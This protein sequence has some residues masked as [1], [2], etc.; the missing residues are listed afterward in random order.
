MDALRLDR[1]WGA[2]SALM[3]QLV[4]RERPSPGRC[5]YCHLDLPVSLPIAPIDSKLHVLTQCPGC[6]AVHHGEC[7]WDLGMC[8]NCKR[9]LD[10]DPAPKLHPPPEI[11]MVSA[12][13]QAVTLRFKH[14]YGTITRCTRCEGTSEFAVEHG[15]C[16]RCA[17]ADVRLQKRFTWIFQNRRVL[18]LLSALVL[19]ACTPL[20]PWAGCVA[21]GLLVASLLG[22]AALSPRTDKG[23]DKGEVK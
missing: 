13:P 11:T 17:T 9:P 4:V 6:R 15:L 12:T 16:A 18:M 7:L 2:S 1:P 10:V 20:V 23:E 22:G 5:A 3:E 14:P 8:A 19:I 21:Q